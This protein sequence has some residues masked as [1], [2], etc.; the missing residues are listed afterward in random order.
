ERVNLR[1][2]DGGP[3]LLL[4]ELLHEVVDGVTVV[5]VGHQVD[6]LHILAVLAG[7]NWCNGLGS[8]V[9]MM[10][11]PEAVT[12]AILSGGVAGTTDDR[13]VQC[14]GSVAGILQGD[15]HRAADASRNHHGLVLTDEARGSLHSAVRFGLRV[16]DG[17]HQLLAQNAL[18]GE[19]RYLLDSWVAL[20]DEFSR[21]LK[22]ALLARTFRRIWPGEVQGQPGHNGVT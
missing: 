12:A 7:E 20:V 4:R 11:E 3:A 16:T 13:E 8:R 22:P 1:V 19:G 14:L 18:L 6:G 15:G 10:A 2:V 21:K 9:G 5:V 17:Q